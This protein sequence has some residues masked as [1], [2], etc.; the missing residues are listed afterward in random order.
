MR[1]SISFVATALCFTLAA[2]SGQT[3]T[4]TPGGP[5]CPTVP[6][7][8]AAFSIENTI[9]PANF[10]ASPT[11]NI[12]SNILASIVGGAQEIRER[13]IYNSQANTLTST[14]FTVAVGSPEPTPLSANI[15][16]TTLGAFTIALTNIYQSCTPTPSI[17]FVGNVTSSSGGALIAAGPLGSLQ[18]ALVAVSVGY[19]N[20][21]PTVLSNVVTLVAGTAVAYSSTVAGTVTFPAAPVTP[22]TSSGSGP[23]IV[24]N[25]AFSSTSGLNQVTQNPI[26]LDASGTQGALTYAWSSFPPVSFAPGTAN[27][28]MEQV[29]FPGPGTYTFTLTVT[30]ATGTSTVTF[31]I[32]F[33]GR[34]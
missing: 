3:T 34:F 5:T 8:L 26:S 22:P 13:L 1:T 18:G 32:N 29:N 6:T 33:V 31:P 20:A 12:P 11:P 24:L 23:I 21:S 25:P 9:A 27:G 2:A 15:L 14:I 30:S 4:A 28:A 17:L 19:T 7:S 16:G 10:L